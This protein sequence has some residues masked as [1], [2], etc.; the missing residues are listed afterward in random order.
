VIQLPTASE[1]RAIASAHGSPFHLYDLDV[2]E[3]R[4]RALRAALPREVDVAYAVKANPSLAVVSHLRHLGLGADVAS[5]GELET[6]LRAG[7]PSARIVMTGPGKRD[8]ELAAAVAAGIGAI[9]VESLGELARLEG[10]AARTGSRT[11]LLLRRS[12]AGAGPTE[13]TRLVSDAGTG[14]FGMD[15]ADIV[16]AARQALGSSHLDVL[17]IHA[18]GASNVTDA[19]SLARHIRDTV[20]FARDVGSATGFRPTVVDVGGGLG[21]PYTDEDAPLDLEVLGSSLTEMVAGWRAD[22]QLRGMRVLLEPGRYL[23]GPAGAFITQ[24]VDR[25]RVRGAE[26]AVLDGG[27]HHLLR[28]ALT[29][30]VHRAVRLSEP[31][32]GRTRLMPVALV[33]PLCSG[34]DILATEIRLPELRVGDHVAILDTGA[35]GF[36]ESMPFFLSHPIPAELVRRGDRLSLIRPRLEPR[37]WLDWQL[38]PEETGPLASAARAPAPVRGGTA[39]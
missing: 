36:T 4:A 14:K 13:R 7:I 38:L 31:G 1:A 16:T 30:Q 19:A 5:A 21:I 15:D 39:V 28:P 25:K 24:V 8:D 17:G 35:Y 27:I 18:F 29:G 12:L 6:V 26:V 10:I 33:G 23:V 32:E 2:I 3:A 11:R 9:T 20:E 34:L 22:L 37:T